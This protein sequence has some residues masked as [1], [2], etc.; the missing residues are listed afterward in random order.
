MAL[1][2]KRHEKI[3]LRD[4]PEFCEA[5]LH[6]QICEDTTLLGLGEL[7]VIGRER[8]Q[9]AGGRL[10]ILLA[11]TDPEANARYEVEVMLGPT[12]PNHIIRCI[13]YWDVERRRYPAYNHIAVL[14]AEEVTSR[15]LNVMSLLSGNIPLVA[16]QLNA[17]QVDEHL[18]LD[19]IKVLDQRDLREDDT[20]EPDGP[21]AD[22]QW[23]ESRKG[24]KSLSLCDKLL[25]IANEKAKRP[26]ELRYS[27]SGVGIGVPGSFFHVLV[28]WPKKDFIPFRLGVSNAEQ[29]AIRLEKEGIEAKTKKEDRLVVR[30]TAS[31][32][33]Q[34]ED[35]IRELIHQCVS[36][37][38][39]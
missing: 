19:F 34:H 5:W 31:D 21:K 1:S 26:L 28:T 25:E 8:T 39:A 23:W 10:D 30:V 24:S 32:F 18:V 33:T 17:L 9:F 29:W 22:R 35:L 3:S 14:V 36:E 13:E 6:D 7:D 4:H 20:V 11:D 37:F 16:I 27:K 38:D 12:D 2:F 15:F